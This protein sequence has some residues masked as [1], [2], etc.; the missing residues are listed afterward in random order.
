[1]MMWQRSEGIIPLA[2]LIVIY[3][4]IRLAVRR[5]G[6]L[7]DIST[8]YVLQ[9]VRFEYLTRLPVKIVALSDVTPCGRVA[10]YVSE[11]PASSTICPE[12]GGSLLLRNVGN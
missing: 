8:S 5:A 7:V 9:V 6:S 10:S 2:W 11:E 12:D 4:C 1:M 3:T